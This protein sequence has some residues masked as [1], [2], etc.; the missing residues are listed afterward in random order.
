MSVYFELEEIV[1]RVE[2]NS[3]SAQGCHMCLIKGMNILKWCKVDTWKDVLCF[4][5]GGGQNTELLGEQYHVRTVDTKKR[6]VSLLI[7]A[8]CAQ[9]FRFTK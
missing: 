1:F 4:Q 3:G 7:V 9:W 5:G 8:D 2:T 6:N